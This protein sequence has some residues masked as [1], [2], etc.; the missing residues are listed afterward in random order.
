MGCRDDT[1]GRGSDGTSV[2]DAEMTLGG[3][4]SDGTRVW[5]TE[6]TWVGGGVSDDTVGGMDG[7]VGRAQVWP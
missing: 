3:R 2:W 4:G 5:D 6:M 7:R 1:R